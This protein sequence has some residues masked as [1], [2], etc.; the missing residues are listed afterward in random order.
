MDAL[1]FLV[2]DPKQSINVISPLV[3]GIMRNMT[4]AVLKKGSFFGDAPL[5][6]DVPSRFSY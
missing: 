6:F 4:V 3:N 1:Y 5:L 2:K